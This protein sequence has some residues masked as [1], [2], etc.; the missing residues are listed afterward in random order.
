MHIW[1]SPPTYSQQQLCRDTAM[2]FTPDKRDYSLLPAPI[3]VGEC[4]VIPKEQKHNIATFS[5]ACDYSPGLLFPIGVPGKYLRL[6]RIHF[7]LPYDVMWLWQH[8]QVSWFSQSM[9]L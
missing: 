3:H 1:C 6:K 7:Q 9:I 2:E 4:T 8:N 5:G